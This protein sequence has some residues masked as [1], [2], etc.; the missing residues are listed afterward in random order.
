M[1]HELRYRQKISF[2]KSMDKI[3]AY[4][5]WGEHRYEPRPQTFREVAQFFLDRNVNPN[6][7]AERCRDYTEIVPYF[8][9]LIGTTWTA[10]GE[11]GFAI[12][13]KRTGKV[14]EEFEGPGQIVLSMYQALLE[15]ACKERDRT[16]EEE[17]Y[18][19]L[20]SALVKGIASMEAFLND[21]AQEWNDIHP[22]DRLI[23]SKQNKVSFDDKLKVW[24]PKMTQGLKL[25]FGDDRWR[26]FRELR[27]I[28]DDQAIHPKKS[29]HVVSYAQLA[30]TV[31]K[32]RTGIVGMLIQFH[33]VFYVLAPAVVIN[34]FYMPDVEVIEVEDT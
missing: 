28:R 22:D 8:Q 29:S 11:G 15:E 25:D 12:F 27:K 30:E 26:H 16:V 13:D 7:V 24:I 10:V 31:N 14:V 34:A 19:A 1:A 2:K 20:H 5:V 18:S 3:W 9:N 21:R 33:L 4:A 17:S 6:I 32:F 23:D